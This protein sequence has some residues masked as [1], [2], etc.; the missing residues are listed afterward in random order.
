[1]T[2][3]SVVRRLSALFGGEQ[4]AEQLARG[5]L[6]SFFIQGSGAG[7]IFLSELVLARLLGASGYGLFATVAAWLQVLVI[8]ALL[9]SNHLL[10]RFV[11]SYLASGD[12]ALLRGLVLQCR[13]ISLA[14][15]VGVFFA[16][17]LILWLW[18]EGLG[19]ETRL[20]FVIGIAALPLAALALQ[21]QAI[22]RGLHHVAAAQAPE[23]IVRP[24]LLML[25]V[26][27]LAWVLGGSVSAPQALAMNGLAILA[28]FIL[29]RFWQQ[30]AMPAAVRI[31]VPVIQARP[32][33]H[34]ALPLFL[35][36]GMQLLIVRMDIIFLGA[37]VGHEQAGHYAAASRVADLIV[38]A[39]ASANVVVAPLIAG[40]HARNDIAGLQRMLTILAKGVL[41]VTI[42]LVA[43]VG[44][45][46][47]TILGLFG[48]GYRS[49]YVPLLILTCGQVVNALSGPV[50]FVMAMTGQQLKM[51]QILALATGLNVVLNF[52]LIPLIGLTGAAIAT[53]ATTVF[54]NLTMRRVVCRR[55]GVDGS[56]LVLLRGRA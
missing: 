13:R 24:L 9:G 47:E 45:F 15:G 11:P 48:D 43:L 18:F 8:V 36:A 7:L 32:W 51:L 29:G 6:V 19:V 3:A 35:I 23:L 14:I 52:A 33:L 10:L 37:L 27:I 49:A 34:I 21:R 20:S 53:A 56:A 1:M 28:A 31:T 46:G 2:G 39:L 25:L 12:W 41:V 17:V 26:V 44:Y 4:V 55:L 5:S 22:L 30:R 54:W 16:A 38:F 42:P 40:L 50:D